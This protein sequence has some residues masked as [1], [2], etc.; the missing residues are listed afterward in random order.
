MLRISLER[1]ERKQ[2]KGEAREDGEEE[3]EK[4][5]ERGQR[6][7]EMLDWGRR[8]EEELYLVLFAFFA[9]IIRNNE[10]R[11]DICIKKC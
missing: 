2:S 10:K 6:D 5:L 8:E 7:G 11:N 1:R 4:S 9:S 3:G